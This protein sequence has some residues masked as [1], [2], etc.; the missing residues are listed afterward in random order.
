MANEPAAAEQ[1]YT[2]KASGLV[3]DFSVLD[4]WIYNVL[5]INPIVSGTVSFFLV[6][7]TYPRASIWL[8]ILIA[9]FFCIFLAI[10]YSCLVAI[11]PRSGGDYIFQSRT[12]GGA[13][14]TICAFT[15]S[16][17]AQIFYMGIAGFLLATQILSPFLLMLGAE[18]NA[19][20]L[21]DAGEWL[22]TDWGIFVMGFVATAFA[23]FINLIGLRRYALA[24]R[25]SFWIGNA[26]LLA[27]I[28]LL[29][30]SSKQDFI[31]HFN[32]FMQSTYGVNHAYDSVV[33]QGPSGFSFSLKDTIFA[34]VVA[35]FSLIYPAWGVQQAGEVRKA[36]AL[37][38]NLRAMVGAEV[39]CF[40]LLAVLAAL[41]TS[42]VGSAFLYGA[43][44]GFA[45]GESVLPVPPFFGFFV[46][47]LGNAG[48]FIFLAGIMYLS[49]FLMNWPNAC[50]GSTRTTMAMSFDRVLPP[51]LGKVSAR[52]HT[53]IISIFLFG[54]L[55]LV[56]CALYSFSESFVSLLVSFFLVNVVAFAGSM[57]A[58]I[59]LPFRRR[60]LYESTAVAR[61]KILGLPGISV[62]AG[63]WLIFAVW[64]AIRCLTADEL[65]VNSTKGLIFL[66]CLYGFSTVLYIGS[67]LYHRS[68]GV[69]LG[70]SYRE[71]PAE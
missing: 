38:S 37:A 68:T 7:V 20:W 48:I 25:Y 62:A 9:G 57:L 55:G 64:I 23:V 2:R 58:A 69:G 49:S 47:V 42:R 50:L 10:A 44:S 52:F 18:Y 6:T 56:A 34:T 36:N 54:V 67:A 19:N 30:F 22:L 71:L 8:A 12:F 3:R 41:I 40:T 4:T 11:M 66:G 53:P 59:V 29:L 60:Q 35:A 17:L 1:P 51:A 32:S 21:M 63:I 43:Q 28:L 16:T 14:G 27:A 61:F 33:S 5:A 31:N 39:F 45:E 13:F 15:N 70:A 65:G 24:Q 46:V 26:C